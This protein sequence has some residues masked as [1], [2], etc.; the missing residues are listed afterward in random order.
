MRNI[1]LVFFMLVTTLCGGQNVVKG[2]IEEP[3]APLVERMTWGEIEY[4]GDPWVHNMSR[5]YQVHKGL[6]GRHLSVTASHGSY[7]DQSGHRWTWQRPPL[8]CT[9]EDL[10]TQTFAVPFLYPMLEKA[11]AIVWTARERCWNR[12]EVIV[13]NDTPQKNGVYIEQSGDHEWQ[14]AGP[15]FAW[16]HEVYHDKDNPHAE[17]TA[18]M[19]EAQTS[20]RLSSS[21]VW[22]PHIKKEGEYAVYVRYPSTPTNVPD[23]KY[24]IRHNGISTT[25]RVNQQMGGN[26]WVYVGTYDFSTGIS[27]DNS[28]TLTN[29]SNYRGVVAADAIRLGGGMGNIERTDSVGIGPT[30]SGLPRYLEGSRYTSFWY[31]MPY[32]VYSAKKGTSDYGD[33][34]NARPMATNYL[35]RG[36]VYLPGDS[37]LNVPIEMTLALHSDAGWRRDMGHIGSLAIYTSDFEEGVLPSGLSR[38]AVS[39][40]GDIFLS[41]AKNDLNK[42][43]GHWVSRENRDGNYGETRVPRTPGAIFE[44]FSHQNFAEML[45][46]HDPTFKF[47]MAR[48]IYKSILRY[49]AQTHQKTEDDIVVSPLPIA[50][51]AAEADPINNRIN[52]SWKAVE[53]VLEKSA[54]P[55]SFV[56]YTAKGK[57]GWDNG[58]IVQSTSYQ[59]DAESNTLYRF[60]VEALN[61]GGASMPSEELCAMISDKRN[62]PNVLIVNGFTRLASPQP[63]DNDSLRG[64]VMSADPGVAFHHTPEYCGPQ[65]YFNKDGFPYETSNGLGY[66]SQEWIGMLIKGNT[67]DYPTLHARD[68][69]ASGR[70]HISSCSRKAFEEKRVQ[71]NSYRLIDVIMGAQRKDGYSRNNYTVFTKPMQEI[72]QQ[73]TEKGGSLLVSGAYVGIDTYASSSS[74]EEDA[75]FKTATSRFVQH[76]LHWQSNHEERADSVLTI[77]GMNTSATLLTK[78]NEEHLSTPRTS[79][80]QPVGNDAYSILLYTGTNHSAAV[81]Y[82]GTVNRTITLG[83]PIEQIVEEGTRQQ[84]M[85]AFMKFLLAE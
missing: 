70:F 81:A 78:P 69:A 21:I 20:K 23:A 33:D 68:M 85:G 82:K 83:F 50:A 72:L 13:D 75:E 48:A 55:T 9:T 38:K 58:T 27:K 2:N 35:S 6:Q 3:T 59:I 65:R 62:S 80:L 36:S 25:V 63:L 28:I 74:E 66:S 19:V 49:V 71:A 31:G 54:T 67:F 76:T 22:T 60:K 43:Y 51:F 12:E 7:Y 32:H 84:L 16:L 45:L 73:F 42:L 53:D 61:E 26:T 5:P 8:Y 34:I 1:L 37:G 17:G 56:V 52:L 24:V 4:R 11:G 47:H 30:V 79:I 40:L 14:D 15:G 41:Q 29:V 57:G 77:Q 39:A 46:A 10:L 44:M 64:F 18:R